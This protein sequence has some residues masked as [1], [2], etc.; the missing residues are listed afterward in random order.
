MFPLEKAA[1]MQLYCQHWL[2]HDVRQMPSAQNLKTYSTIASRI[3]Q[4]IFLNCMQKMA[5][6]SVCAA[7]IERCAVGQAFFLA[8]HPHSLRCAALA[9]RRQGFVC[10]LVGLLHAGS[11]PH[12]WI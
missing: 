11:P 3:S 5:L 12:P 7:V 10:S 8:P 4:M 9:T 1:C 2:P 6:I